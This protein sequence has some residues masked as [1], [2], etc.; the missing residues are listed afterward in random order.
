MN[1]IN[2]AATKI[3]SRHGVNG[4]FWSSQPSSRTLLPAFLRQ[5]FAASVRDFLAGAGSD[6]FA[7]AC[8]NSVAHTCRDR[9]ERL[10]GLQCA[11]IRG[12]SQ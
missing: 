2:A 1:A 7:R 5:S 12:V 8:R 11:E 3:T 9:I 6:C 10:A 4:R